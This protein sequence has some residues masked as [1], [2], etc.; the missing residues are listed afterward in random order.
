MQHNCR[1]NVAAPGADS[2]RLAGSSTGGS[3]LGHSDSGDGASVL[4]YHDV[5]RDEM[6]RGADGG[7]ASCPS[8]ELGGQSRSASHAVPAR[9][10]KPNADW[11]P[12]SEET[13]LSASSHS[14]PALALH[15]LFI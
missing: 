4:R 12:R 2:L 6:W 7:V 8:I 1:S 3:Q 11:T 14:Q 5:L 15:R 10:A 13:D 9:R